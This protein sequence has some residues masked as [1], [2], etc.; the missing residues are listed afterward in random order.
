MFL[1][2]DASE[3]SRSARLRIR[4][5]NADRGDRLRQPAGKPA[6]GRTHDARE[7][8]PH[9]NARQEIPQVFDNR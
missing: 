7:R 5:W 1:V 3:G 2:S 9:H 6:R 4:I 8:G